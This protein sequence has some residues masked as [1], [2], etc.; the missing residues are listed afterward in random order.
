M[1]GR[2]RENTRGPTVENFSLALEV[3]SNQEGSVFER[4]GDG[5]TKTLKV[6]WYSN[7]VFG[8]RREGKG[9]KKS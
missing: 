2:R 8:G 5:R 3:V 1:A 9:E 4:G 6:L 7:A